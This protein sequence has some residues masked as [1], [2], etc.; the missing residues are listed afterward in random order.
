[1]EIEQKYNAKV[2]KW[3]PKEWRPQYEEI[4][5][6]S[7]RGASNK[8]LA[9]KHGVSPQTICNINRTEMARKIRSELVANLRSTGLGMQERRLLL[10]D[11]ALERIEEYFERDD[12]AEKNPGA[13]AD[14]AMKLL[15]GVG[16]LK[17]EHEGSRNVTVI[18]DVLG[19][20]LIAALTKSDQVREKYALPAKGDRRG[21]I[22]VSGGESKISQG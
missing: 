3:E 12:V 16:Q 13:M 21:E 19:E 11:K 4:V 18:G 10:A 14:R 2:K 6:E 17:S 5:L 20:K 7:A 22:I 8:S 1:M 15:T 9:E